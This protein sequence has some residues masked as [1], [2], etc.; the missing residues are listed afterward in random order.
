MDGSSASPKK[1]ASL[2]DLDR[3]AEEENQ[4]EIDDFEKLI[5]TFDKKDDYV[6]NYDKIRLKAA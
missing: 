6:L 2:V 1:P 5:D 3:T 4:M